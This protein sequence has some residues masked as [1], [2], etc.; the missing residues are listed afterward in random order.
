[1]EPLKHHPGWW[2]GH[3]SEQYDFVNWDGWWN[4]QYNT[5]EDKKNY[6]NQTT[7][8]M[9]NEKWKMMNEDYPVAYSLIIW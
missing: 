6:G 5:W 7:N 1:M 4:S 9:K 3:P 2:L 8:Q